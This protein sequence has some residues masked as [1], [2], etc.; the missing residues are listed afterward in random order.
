MPR[1]QFRPVRRRRRTPGP[2]AWAGFAGGITMGA[3]AATL[4]TGSND[5]PPPQ[6]T[7]LASGE[8]PEALRN[9]VA[10]Y[11]A[12][13][14]YLPPAEDTDDEPVPPPGSPVL[15]T[16][17][18]PAPASVPVVPAST[19][20]G[21]NP[22]PIEFIPEP[23]ALP[24]PP[25]P[26]TASAQPLDVGAVTDAVPAVA[27]A[28]AD[29]VPAAL[30]AVTEPAPDVLGT[31]SAPAAPSGGADGE[32]VALRM[33]EAEPAPAASD[34]AAEPA[35]AT[36][37]VA[38]DASSNTALV[39]ARSVPAA[40]PAPFA[41]PEPE[42]SGPSVAEVS[43]G[44]VTVVEAAPEPVKPK[45]EKP[46]KASVSGHAEAKQGRLVRDT[47]TAEAH[48]EEEPREVVTLVEAAEVAG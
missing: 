28:A 23:L 3:L 19:R 2:L 33:A 41:A 7:Q 5:Q 47:V 17:A 26:L 42:I 48:A 39:D 18:P 11:L 14:G 38:A 20:G 8:L 46:V 43:A 15:P 25:S 4:I 1:R 37:L 12:E 34:A 32:P 31:D 22:W 16:P 9:L 45:K 36:P 10:E 44:E 35:P 29:A 40:Q 24:L 21:S 27:Q 30:R 6:T 13:E